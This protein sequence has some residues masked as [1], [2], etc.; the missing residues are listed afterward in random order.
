MARRLINTI[1]WLLVAGSVAIILGGLSGRPVLL[2]AVPTGSMV[3]ILNP[4]DVIPVIPYFGGALEKGEIIVFRTEQD[5]NWIVH[6]IRSGDA[7]EGFVTRGDANLEDDPFR[8]FPKDVVGTVPQVGRNAL[9]VPRMGLLSL[10]RNPLS[11][12]LIAGI[13]LI[14][15]IYLIASDA[16]A[17]L[18][19]VRG[20]F[21]L[22]RLT[23]RS[24]SAKVTLGL[25]IGLAMATYMVTAVTMWSLGSEQV[26]KFRVV[27]TKSTNVQLKD[28]YYLGQTKTESITI[29]NPSI[30]P[31]MVGLSGGGPDAVWEP[32][33]FLLWPGGEREV[34]LSVT[35]T[36]VGDQE[37]TIRQ[38]V[39]LPFL[40]LPVIRA[41]A[42]SNWHLPIFVISLVPVLGILVLAA[43]DH[44]VWA[45]LHHLKLSM[46]LRTRG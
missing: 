46:D 41:L 8:V 28:L 7:T 39:F 42:A 31:L 10:E 5:P 9:R 1:V 34:S 13:A 30:L 19:F 20:S 16:R 38:G 26:A 44:R 11:N 35:A 40:P 21:R 4:G 22:G 24:P 18:R 6:R 37:L 45:E 23:S 32:D 43:S 17:G 2:A 25:Y 12:P 14:F 15:G 29:K 36:S 3:P 33:W 27:Q